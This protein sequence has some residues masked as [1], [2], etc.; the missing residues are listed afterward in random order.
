VREDRDVL[1]DELV[2]RGPYRWLRL[3]QSRAWL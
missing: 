1:A 2:L 3:S